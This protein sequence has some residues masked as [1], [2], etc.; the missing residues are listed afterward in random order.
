MK[1]V[2][3]QWHLG[4]VVHALRRAH[5]WNY[6]ELMAHAGTNIRDSQTLARLEGDPRH[7]PSHATITGLTHAFHLTERQLEGLIPLSA[8]LDRETRGLVDRLAAIEPARRT[9]IVRALL[10]VLLVLDQA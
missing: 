2:R 6:R 10:Q 8:S 1:A 5:D 9:R 4:T 7:R 3:L